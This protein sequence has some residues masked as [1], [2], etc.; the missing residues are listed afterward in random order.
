MTNEFIPYAGERHEVQKRQSS[1]KDWFVPMAGSVNPRLAR[2]ETAQGFYIAGADGTAYGWYHQFRDPQRVSAFMDGAVA[3]FRQKPPAAVDVP[4]QNVKG[5]GNTPPDPSTSVVRI[6]SRI[7]PLP[8][9]ADRIAMAVGR[10]HIWIYADEVKAMVDA[11]AKVGVE[12][13]LPPSIVFRLARF[14]FISNVKGQPG[15]WKANEV[16]KAAVSAKVIA[17][18]SNRRTL[19]LLGEFAI[20]SPTGADGFTGKLEGEL[21]LDAKTNKVA[22]FR[23]YVEGEGFGDH[24]WARGSEYAAR[25]GT[26]GR[27]PLVFALVDAND[28]VARTLPPSALYYGAPYAKP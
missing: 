25:E 12:F 11:S 22:R 24:S 16:Q 1:I 8:A 28:T 23:A 2:N 6:F 7:R 5:P 26:R 19:S 18:T 9:E 20:E 13:A 10:D 3:K 4:Q 15:T 14:H 17:V 21:E 27:F